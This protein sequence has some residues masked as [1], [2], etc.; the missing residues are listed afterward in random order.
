MEKDWNPNDYQGRSKDQVERK[1][2]YLNSLRNYIKNSVDFSKLPAPSIA[3][4]E[5]PN[6]NINVAKIISLS[7]Q[8]SE[9]AYSVKGSFSYE[10]LDNEIQSVKKVLLENETTYR[11]TLMYDLN[12]AKQK[13]A[14]TPHHPS[15]LHQYLLFFID[16]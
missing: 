7:I 8:R 11:N 3:G 5:D 2:A 13:R 9:L 1:L 15:T 10:R 16:K 4:I 6:I 14:K 12:I